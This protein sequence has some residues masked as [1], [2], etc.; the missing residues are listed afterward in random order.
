MGGGFGV[1]LRLVMSKRTAQLV[2]A[3]D[4]ATR[5]DAQAWIEKLASV[6]DVFKVGLELFTACGPDI[7]DLV[8]AS[9]KACFLDLKLHDIAQTVQSTVNVLIG[10][11]VRYFTL[12]AANGPETL[13]RVAKCCAG[14]ATQPLAVTVLTNLDD[15]DM[16]QMGFS[17]GASQTALK[18]AQMSFAQ[19]ITGFVCSALECEALRQALGDKAV[20]TVPGVRL[21]QDDV[22]DQKRVATPAEVVKRGA[23]LLVVG[24]PIRQAQD[25][26]QMA[27][28]IRLD[29]LS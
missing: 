27:R 17:A 16:V 7:I 29:M 6:V 25:P 13:A 20:L 4:V 2:F 14:T 1:D 23:D 18:L 26:V 21:V 12:H 15:N 8:H 19:G 5:D 3:L 24:R 28:A 22:H 9:G 11:K 10:T